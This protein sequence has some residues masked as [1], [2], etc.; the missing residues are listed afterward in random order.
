[1]K[2]IETQAYEELM[3]SLKGERQNIK[4]NMMFNRGAVELPRTDVFC[5]WSLGNVNLPVEAGKSGI[6]WKLYI[7]QYLCVYF[8]VITSVIFIL[9]ENS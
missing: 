7:Y 9:L 2:G 6:Y 8:V 5:G 1:M 4:I 3:K